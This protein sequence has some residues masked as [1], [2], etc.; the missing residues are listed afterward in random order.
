VSIISTSK[1]DLEI[2][3]PVVK[4]R[5]AWKLLLCGNTKG[6]ELLQSG[7]LD[8]FLD[9]GS[10]KITMASIHR[11][12]D[13]RLIVE[14][15]ALTVAEAAALGGPCRSALYQDIKRGR[16]RAVKR[17][18]STRILIEDYKQYLASLPPLRR[19]G[20]APIAATGRDRAD[21]TKLK[22]QTSFDFNEN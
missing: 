4:P 18:R 15:L 8:S 22:N 14:K 16:L 21:A 6:Y 1:P 10:R 2:E 11:Y 7:E 19:T 9:G 17:G 12:I 3:P 5:V 20:E 13:M